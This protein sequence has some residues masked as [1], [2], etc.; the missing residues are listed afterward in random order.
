MATSGHLA[1]FQLARVWFE[2]DK[3]AIRREITGIENLH[4]LVVSYEGRCCVITETKNARWG[5]Q[6]KCVVIVPMFG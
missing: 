6:S 5:V 2:E 3:R 1:E 4:I